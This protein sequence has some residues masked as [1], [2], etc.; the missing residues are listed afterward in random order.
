MQVLGKIDPVRKAKVDQAARRPLIRGSIQIL[1]R[2]WQ[3]GRRGF[4]A[5]RTPTQFKSDLVEAIV[6]ESKKHRGRRFVGD[7]GSALPC[8]DP[9]S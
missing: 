6:N 3:E 8:A 1:G 2:Q 7:Y 5:F 9:G 4:R